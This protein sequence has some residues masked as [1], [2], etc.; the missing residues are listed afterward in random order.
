MQWY[1]GTIHLFVSLLSRFWRIAAIRMYHD[2][3]KQY[4]NHD[5]TVMWI[6]S[7]HFCRLKWFWSVLNVAIG[8]QSWNRCGP[9][10]RCTADR[11]S[12]A[13]V[14]VLSMI[15]YFCRALCWPGLCRLV[16]SDSHCRQLSTCINRI[17]VRWTRRSIT[18][19][20]EISF[21]KIM[22][23]SMNG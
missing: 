23:Q 6:V 1:I 19:T 3:V 8:H 5:V 17:G 20:V 13:I 9:R 4:L 18:A 21:V 11:K 14:S 12:P 10:T 2:C 22:F 15:V 7:R 16:A